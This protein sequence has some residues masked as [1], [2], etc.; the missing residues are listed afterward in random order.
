MQAH[1][2]HTLHHLS[3]DITRSVATD[4][5]HVIC[6]KRKLTSDVCTNFPVKT[7]LA[8]LIYNNGQSLST[9]TRSEI[10]N[11]PANFRKACP[12]LCLLHDDVSSQELHACPFDSLFYLSQTLLAALK[13]GKPKD[14]DEDNGPPTFPTKTSC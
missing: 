3:E 1:G 4:H 13:Q 10:L 2:L 6:H 5:T 8:H 12:I 9:T 14:K 7:I 11:I